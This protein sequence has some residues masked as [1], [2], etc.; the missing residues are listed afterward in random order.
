MQELFGIPMGPLATTLAA[1]LVLAIGV[2]AALAVRNR[3][4]FRLGVRNI[5]RRPAR[6][7]L[8]VLGLMLATTII[9]SA[10]ATGDTMSTTIRSSVL[11]TYGQT[12]EVIS[13]R[14]AKPDERVELGQATSVEYIPATRFTEIAHALLQ[15]GIVD[16]VAPAIV[17]PIAVQDARSRQNEPRVTLFA[18]DPREMKGFGEIRSDGRTGALA[19]LARGEIYLNRDAAE[20]LDA[21]AGDP[22]RVF[23]GKRAFVARVRSIV[24]YDGAGTDGAAVLVPLERAQALLGRQGEIK[25]VLVSNRGG[26]TSGAVL[27]DQVSRAVEADLAQL[28]LEANAVKEDGLQLADEQ[29][30]TFMSIFLIFVMLAAERRGE[31]GIARAVGMR[32]EHLVQMY[33]F[34]GVAYDLAAAF[35]GALLGILVAMAMVGVMATAFDQE[36]L[37][38]AYSVRPRSM[39]V[40]YA[41]GVLLTFVVVAISAWRVSVLNIVAAVRNLPDLRPRTGRGRRWILSAAAVLAGVAL[42]AAG[43]SSKQMMPFGVGVS[44]VLIGSTA[45]ARAVGVG[46]RAAYT[47]GGL[48]LVAFWLLPFDALD[49]LV[50]DMGMNF[51]VWIVSG[52]MV[53]IGATWVL[54]HNADVLLGAVM[55]VF[56]RI[57]ALAPVLKL[58]MAYPLRSRFRTGVT[59][60]MFTLVV[61]TVVVGATASGSFLRALDD[62][63]EFGGGFDVRAEVAPVS[64]IRDI[65]VA[66]RRSPA[67]DHDVTVAAAQS[68]LPAELRQ[69]RTG[70]FD[71]YQLRGLDEPFL[72]TTTFELG[73]IARGYGSARA[74]W[75][76]MAARRGL[77]VVDA[78]VVPH[79]SNFGFEVP[80]DFQVH[81]F[82]AE[83]T[84]FAP[85][86]IT[87]RDPQTGRRTRLTAIGMLKDSAPY[88]MAGVSTSQ[89]TMEAAFGDRAQPTVYYFETAPGVD[90][91]S[92]AKRLESAFLANGMEADSIESVLHDAVSASWTMNRLLLAFMGLGLVVGVA[93]LGVISARSVV[94]RRQQIGVLR[95]LGFQRRMVQASF[96]LEA[97]VIALTAIFVGTALGL[98]M[99]YNIVADSANQ[100]TWGDSL[101]L[102]IRWMALGVVFVTVY[103]AALL[104]TLAPAVRA[105]RVYPAEALRYQ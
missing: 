80:P 6:T 48:L 57:R 56:G 78:L 97:S 10:L 31:L 21:K 19:D 90:P 85:F 45:L 79:R 44:L 54:M 101:T 82:Y 18:T 104:T 24:E 22:V 3:V 86:P 4:F 33:V 71:D 99:T 30:S 52:L 93:A 96:L 27:S 51:S 76:A 15:T 34:E 47:A 102:S 94:E 61:F 39:L 50:G 95:S 35:V 32:R 59:L 77:A 81:G 65:G 72:R 64:P 37:E 62:T 49:A 5:P 103:A 58:A 55:A 74:V 100:G 41:L 73:A 67:L 63:N 11:K 53:V 91:G 69:G 2:L 14:G 92:V 98:V 66:V 42:T 46:D 20:E 9:A 40:A 60:A 70:G 1:L 16:G 89:A 84:T 8:I 68:F 83:D 23:A 43:I 12:D 75:S 88:S 29:G 26:T 7:A 13:I 17:E 25:H 28:G 87:A 38:I 36:G 105:S